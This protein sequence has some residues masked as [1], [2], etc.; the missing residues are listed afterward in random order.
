MPF[1]VFYAIFEV[2]RVHCFQHSVQCYVLVPLSFVGYWEKLSRTSTLPTREYTVFHRV[3]A[4][5][6]SSGLETRVALPGLSR[7]ELGESVV[8][9]ETVSGLIIVRVS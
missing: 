5:G 8:W 1:S 3:C 7:G 6:V 4:A 9:S 2:F